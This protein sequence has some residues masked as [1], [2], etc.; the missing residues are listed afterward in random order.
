MKNREE[1]GLYVGY[2]TSVVEGF[3][4]WAELNSSAFPRVGS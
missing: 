4:E 1:T 3:Q 2:D